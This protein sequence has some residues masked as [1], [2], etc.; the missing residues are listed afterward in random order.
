LSQVMA[1][2]IWL[3]MEV[4]GSAGSIGVGQPAGRGHTLD[5]LT[6]W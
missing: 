2:G 6:M 1:A 4:L 5:R 3:G